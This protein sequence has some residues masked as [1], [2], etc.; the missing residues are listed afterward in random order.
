MF[1]INWNWKAVQVVQNKRIWDV[2]EV[3]D[4]ENDHI[5][6]LEVVISH[7]VDD[8]IKDDT[9][10]RTDVDPTIVERPV[11]HHV[12]DDFI[13]DVDEHLSHVSIMSYARNNFLEMDVMFLEFE[14]DLDNLAGGSSS[15]GENAGRRAQS[16]LLEFECHVVVNGHIPITIVPGAEKPIS[17]HAVH[18]SQ[19]IGVCVRKTFFVPYLKWA[20]V[21]REY[22]EVVKGDLQRFFVLDFNDQAMNRFV[23]HQILTTLKSFGSIVTDTSK[24]S[25][26]GTLVSAYLEGSQS[27]SGDENCDQV[28]DRRPGYSKGLR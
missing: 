25:N 10:C 18:F 17:P 22:I 13:D 7:R 20:D 28:L 23:E 9:L 19:T 4:V 27:L 5:N 1:I 6:V 21:D 26:A 3:E 14:D 15:V 16:R 8:H 24:K 2:L 11:V 12:T